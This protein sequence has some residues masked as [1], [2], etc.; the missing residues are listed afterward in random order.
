M[1]FGMT[2]HGMDEFSCREISEE[3]GT[4]WGEGGGSPPDPL[5]YHIKMGRPKAKIDKAALFTHNSMDVWIPNKWIKYSRGD[6]Y[7]WRKGL[8]MNLKQRAREVL[9]EH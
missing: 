3:M 9:V 7:V 6:H 4:G 2:N 1:F 5:F 8:L